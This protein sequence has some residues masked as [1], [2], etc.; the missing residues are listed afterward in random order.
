MAKVEF[1]PDGKYVV[2]GGSDLDKTVKI[3][4]A[5]SGNEVMTLYGHDSRICSLAF[6]PDGRRVL[7]ASIDETVRLW[8]AAT[9]AEVMALPAQHAVWS[10]VFS[11]DGKTIA[12]TD[13]NAVTLFESAPL[14]GGY[15]QRQT[16]QEAREAVD[17]WHNEL[18][19]YDEVINRLQVDEVLDEPV[20]GFALQI[21]NSRKWELKNE[22]WEAV[23]F[24]DK[25]ID[26]YQ[27]ALEK[28]EKAKV[29]EPNDPA[30]LNTLGGAQYRLGSYE[31]A[32]KMLAESAR[33]LSDANEQPDPANVAFRA[34]ILRKIDRLEEAKVALE[35][36]RQLCQDEEHL[37]WDMEVQALLAEAEKLIEGEK[38]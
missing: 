23:V 11:P 37:A 20:R 36:L 5:S 33:I 32:L 3:W 25:D 30:I 35:Q 10:A 27:A 22:A 8:D 12:I 7:S 26:E 17:R 4:D 34:M 38:Q 15:G 18:G 14:R 16:A 28:A 29:L 21:A 19:F 13:G 1:S 31:D 6:S 9:G 24:P 2:S